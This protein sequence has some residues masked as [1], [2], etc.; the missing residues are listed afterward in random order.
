MGK[1]TLKRRILRWL[2]GYV[3]LLSTLIA[4]GG[5]VLHERAEHLVWKSLLST[6]L[7]HV[8]DRRA[9]EPDYRWQ[10]SDTLSLYRLG[11]PNVPTALVG[12]SP[13]LHDDLVIANRKSVALVRDTPR[14]GRVALVLDVTDFEA[15]E[16]FASSWILIAALALAV[17]TFVI[18]SYGMRRIVGP[19]SGLAAR[20]GDLR[21]EVAGQRVAPE[22]GATAELVVIADAVNDYLAR[23]EQFVERER[24]FVGSA[25][26]ELRT[27]VAVIAGAA[28]L[29][30]EQDDV[31]TPVRAQIQRIQRTARG[32]EQLI[33]LLLVLARDPLRLAKE[34]DRFNLDELLPHIVDD[35]RHL[36]IGKDLVLILGALPRCVLVAPVAIVQAAIGNLLRNAIENSDR[37]EILVTL[38][39][40]GIVRIDD[41]GHGMSPEEISAIYA[42]M[43]RGGG[44]EGG[45]IGL[46]LIAR[47]CEHL[48]WALRFEP[49]GADAAGASSLSSSNAGAQQ[50]HSRGT[51]VTLDFGPSLLR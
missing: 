13:G 47:L 38:Q 8:V 20:I 17:L 14:D 41:P 19:L 26:H 30:L 16:R 36:C 9:H 33:T 21:P 5:N 24:V 40:D 27:P 35:H 22:K 37:G 10:D 29:A 6:E 45:G 42:R 34:S 39:A 7:A 2:V 32:V 1:G 15:L 51:R 50:P 25:S 23:N 4:I 49:R 12:R 46:D 48:G 3:L 18:A 28:D 11:G 43:A 31:P 44:Q